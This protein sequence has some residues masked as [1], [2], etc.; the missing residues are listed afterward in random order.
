M[1]KP[2]SA[3]VNRARQGYTLPELIVAVVL[4]SIMVVSLL[5]SFS[6]GL[7]LVRL[8]RENLRA[9]QIMMQKMETI[10]LLTWSQGT[11]TVLAPVNFVDWYDPTGTNAHSAG[12]Q[13]EGVI[14]V[15]NSPLGIPSDYQTNMRIITV[16]VFWTNYPHGPSSPI[17]RSRQMQTYVARYGMQP[18][19]YQ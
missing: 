5:G 13:Y 19:V 1:K 6:S 8:Q 16:T 11:N 15:A 18:Y 4:L 7:A 14:D 9:T 17:T 3:D 12:V 2:K 10:R